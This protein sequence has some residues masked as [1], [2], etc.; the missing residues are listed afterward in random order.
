MKYVAENNKLRVF[1]AIPAH[2]C[3]EERKCERVN[4]ISKYDIRI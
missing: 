2:S 3:P 1:V 4:W